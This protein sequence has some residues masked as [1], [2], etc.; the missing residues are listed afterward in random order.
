VIGRLSAFAVDEDLS[1]GK[2][3]S[4]LAVVGI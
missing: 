1:R 3:S 2:G 4:P